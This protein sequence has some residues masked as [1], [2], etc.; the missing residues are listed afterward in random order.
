MKLLKLES[1]SRSGVNT[2]KRNSVS[3]ARCKRQSKDLIEW[4]EETAKA[5][6]NGRKSAGRKDQFG[7]ADFSTGGAAVLCQT[8]QED[9]FE[10]TA[11]YRAAAADAVTGL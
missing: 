10:S 9:R 11:R 6:E 3:R 2:G 7:S 4:M 8:P 1:G 5:V